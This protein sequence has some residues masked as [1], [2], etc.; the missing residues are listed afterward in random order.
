MNASLG[1]DM[2]M[3]G[4]TQTARGQVGGDS[5][6]VDS[7]PAILVVDDDSRNLFA[8]ER[9]LEDIGE[10]VAADSGK[11]ALRQLLSRDF[12]VILLDVIMPDMD[13]YDTAALIRARERTRQ[14]PIIFLTA[15]SKDDAHMLKGYSMGAVDFV[16]KP[17]DT[18][19]LR[20]KVSVFVDLFAKNREIQRKA[21]EEQRLQEENFR[22]RT[23]KILAERA[24][25]RSEE[26]QAAILS[27]LPLALY[28]NEF[29]NRAG[30]A[31][32]GPQFFSDNVSS[33]SGFPTS[34][35]KEEPGLWTDR[36]HP[37]DRE[38]VAEE[39]ER[40]GAANSVACEYRWRCADG[41]YRYFLDQAVVIR[42]EHG[43][44]IEI[45][46]FLSDVTERRQ[47][48]QQLVQAQKLDAIGKLTG[49][50]AHDFNNMLTVVIGCLDRL[51]RTLKDDAASLRRVEMG[52]QGA[53]RCSDLTRR[54]LMFAR[55]QMLRAET[56][57][58]NLLVSG[59]ADMVRRVIGDDIELVLDCEPGQ[60]LVKVDRTQAESALL[61]LV[62]NARDAMPEGGTLTISTRLADGDS[63]GADGAPGHF[64]VLTVKDT[65]IGIPKDV[66][67]RVFEPFFTTKDPGKGTGLGLSIIYG[68]VKESGGNITL[69]SEVGH[70]TSVVIHL[71]REEKDVVVPQIVAPP[72]PAMTGARSGETVLVVEDDEGVRQIAVGILEDL[73][74]RVIE[75]Q[76]AR[77][78]LDLFE[79]TP[80]IH[81]VFTDL[82]MPGMSGRDLAEELAKRE[83][84]A[85]VLLTSA[86]TD[87]LAAETTP[88]AVTGFLHKPYGEGDLAR[89]VRRA[90]DGG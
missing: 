72:R 62:V 85:K 16:F 68:F 64:V 63:L 90:M 15:V 10:V 81:L 43:R 88:N 49:G 50:I 14:V 21:L 78:A 51:R 28:S 1:E 65:G 59:I 52:L 74:Y 70:G 47:L 6:P 80:E 73:G 32:G 39:F 69:D 9:A 48:E 22:V 58:L 37:E 24:L 23:E 76:D 26:R 12:A 84:R 11:E 18:M 67:N 89:A 42:D 34:R 8:M 46:G 7:R 75:A 77:V 5:K 33:L 36:I 56:V 41:D 4:V 3:D 60:L 29:D 83:Q 27:S 66:L 17:V 20:S 35:F 55:R 79:R 25:Q 86:Y 53:L 38:R 71:P 45:V 30:G 13:G 54:L 82:V 19:V 44:P 57:D 2:E 87:R 61:N 31:I 40:L